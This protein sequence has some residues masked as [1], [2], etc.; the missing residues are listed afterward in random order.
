MTHTLV[1]ARASVVLYED[2][3]SRRIRMDDY[4]GDPEAVLEVIDQNIPAWTEKV[5]LKVRPREVAF[6][7]SKGFQEEAFIAGYF[8]GVDM[9]FLVRYLTDERSHSSWVADEEAI[10]QAVL[11]V[12]PAVGSV[13]TV[14][15]KFA[16]PEDAEDLA[17]LYRE[18]FRVYPTPVYDPMH[19]RKTMEEGTLYAF[20]REGQ[21]I[22][23]AA[24]AEI[25][26]KYQNAELTDC[27]TA[28][29]HEGK[30]YMRAL[31]TALEN[32]LKN[33]NI[34]CL[35]TIARSASF[36]M[37]KAFHQLGYT[38]GGRMTKNCMIYSGM[39]DMNVWYKF[40]NSVI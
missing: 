35:Y 18:A 8:S 26:A 23:S 20:V 13:P 5:I 32:H 28:E 37:N 33:R 36:G 39:E 16:G 3:F 10:I 17:R 22:I 4:S 30:G 34:T 14:T 21:K 1:H 9:H 11:L 40:E 38:F 24:S 6:F 2:E 29:G 7:K 25:N 31:L 27:A 19:V 12:A 15:V